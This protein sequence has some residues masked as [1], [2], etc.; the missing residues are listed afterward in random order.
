MGRQGYEFYLKQGLDSMGQGRYDI[1]LIDCP[2]SMG[3]LTLN[4]LTAANLLIIP[5]Q[6]SI[7]RL[8]HCAR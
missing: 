8:R 5:I 1:V 4:A 2:P 6:P 3:T 7:M